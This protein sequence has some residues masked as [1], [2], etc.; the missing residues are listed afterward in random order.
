MEEVGYRDRRADA[1]GDLKVLPDELICAV[2]ENLTCRDIARLACVSRSSLQFSF[3]LWIRDPLF[4]LTLIHLEVFRGDSHLLKRFLKS[5][6]LSFLG[7][8]S[9]CQIEDRDCK[10]ER[11]SYR[12]ILIFMSASC[13]DA[14][15]E[16][17]SGT[18]MR[19]HF[20]VK[21]LL[22]LTGL[23]TNCRCYCILL[24]EDV[25]GAIFSLWKELTAGPWEEVEET[26]WGELKKTSGI[27]SATW[28]SETSYASPFSL[29]VHSS[30]YLCL[31][32]CFAIPGIVIMKSFNVQ[33]SFVKCS[34]ELQLVLR[35]WFNPSRSSGLIT[36]GFTLV[37]S[38][39]LF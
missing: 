25:L 33:L 7:G 34:C 21:S 24:D 15:A 32:F 27:V 35:L 17:L 37:P 29:K 39:R 31:S 3:I 19:R 9:Q 14:L 20:D 10:L 13:D 30:P 26:F 4:D 6:K 36:F 28:W 22:L 1:L 18:E 38:G 23:L 11:L 12:A 16:A 2:L 8:I 5:Y